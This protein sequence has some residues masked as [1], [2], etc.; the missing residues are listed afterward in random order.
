MVAVK[1]RDILLTKVAP[2]APVEVPLL[3]AWCTVQL[4]KRK[5]AT[6]VEVTPIL[7]K[8]VTPLFTE[9]VMQEWGEDALLVKWVSPEPDD[10]DE[11]MPELDPD[12]FLEF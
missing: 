3:G 1:T 7:G 10:E 4:G 6:W 2:L 11:P 9:A 5:F 8:P 12:N